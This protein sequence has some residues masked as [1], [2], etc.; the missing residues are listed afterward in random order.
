MADAQLPPSLD[1]PPHLSAHKYFFVCTLTV[2]AWDTLV[3]SPRSWRLLK[4]PGWPFL[5]IAYHFLRVFMP[6]EFT[7]V[8]VAF[9]DTKWSLSVSTTRMFTHYLPPLRAVFP[10]SV[11][12]E[13]SM[14]GEAKRRFFRFQSVSTNAM[15]YQHHDFK[16]QRILEQTLTSFSHRLVH[17]SS[18][19]N[20]SAQ[21]SSSP[22]ALPFMSSVSMLSMAIHDASLDS[23]LVCSLHK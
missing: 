20:P 18:S 14:L 23:C 13:D 1:L 12:M 8:G 6:V 19:L 15:A 5:K 21:L 16:Q 11:A 17:I 3:L 10:S 4:S 7:I 2:A 9:F 22:S